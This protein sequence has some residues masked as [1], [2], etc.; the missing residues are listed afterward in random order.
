V[1]PPA[2]PSGPRGVAPW[3]RL[4]ATGIVLFLFIPTVLVLFVRHPAP[5]A[6]SLLAGIALIVGHRALAR[7][8]MAAARARKC[9]WCNGRLPPD[10]VSQPLLVPGGQLELRVCAAH[11]SLLARFLAFVDRA[12]LPLRLGIFLPLVALLAGL[13]TSA[14]TGRDATWLASVTA[15]F[16][17][18]V[19]LT[20][21]VAA[22]GP[23]L[24]RPVADGEP[25]A[26]FPVHNFYLLGVR[27]LLW[28][29]RLVGIVWIVVG[30]RGL[31][32]SSAG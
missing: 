3:W 9:V 24:A 23:F 14:L 16:Q 4:Q 6:A 25:R 31:I 12:R 13:A 32:V 10:A 11:A 26:A 22:L 20:V 7:P 15:W 30:L 18:I 5:I 17:L 21:N 2:T 8:Y 27:T 19:G 28:I 1:H 29:F